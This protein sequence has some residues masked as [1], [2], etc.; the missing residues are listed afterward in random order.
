MNSLKRG[1]AGDDDVDQTVAEEEGAEAKVF[2]PA[3]FAL[4]VS[5]RRSH[6]V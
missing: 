4:L 1:G 2:D 3:L 5:S 6:L